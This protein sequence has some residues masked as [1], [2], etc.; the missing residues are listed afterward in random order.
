MEAQ[1]IRSLLESYE[2]PCLLKPLTKLPSPYSPVFHLGGVEVL[3][4]KSV[5]EEAKKLIRGEEDA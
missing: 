3:V 1:V 5:A 2:I 4:P